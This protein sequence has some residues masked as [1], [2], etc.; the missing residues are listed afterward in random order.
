MSGALTRLYLR[1]LNGSGFFNNAI[2]MS[3]EAGLLSKHIFLLLARTAKRRLTRYQPIDWM[4]SEVHRF[5]VFL[6]N[7]G[8]NRFGLR[9]RFFNLAG[10]SILKYRELQC[11]DKLMHVAKLEGSVDQDTTL[12]FFSFMTHIFAT[13]PELPPHQP[14]NVS[15]RIAADAARDTAHLTDLASLYLLCKNGNNLEIHWD[16]AAA[17]VQLPLSM[18]VNERHRWAAHRN[19]F[20]L[21][22]RGQRPQVS[23]DVQASPPLIE[24]PLDTRKH[25]NDYIKSAVP[26]SVII[27]VSLKEGQDGT[28][29]LNEV[30]PW[31]KLFRSMKED[32]PHVVFVLLNRIDG[33]E[34]IV[35]P[36]FVR[37]LR[38]HGFTLMQSIAAAQNTDMYLGVLDSFGL[39]A[40]QVRVPGVYLPLEQDRYETEG[41]DNVQFEEI[42]PRCYMPDIM[43]SSP[44][45]KFQLDRILSAIHLPNE[46]APL[47]F[48]DFIAAKAV[49]TAKPSTRS[50]KP[51]ASQKPQ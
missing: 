46:S 15:I 43:P 34:K 30:A 17:D 33:W 27:G 31:L 40:Y 47:P 13:N 44:A 36:E 37:P 22:T 38:S 11:T 23:F 20:A 48:D 7:M 28:I 45:L 41:S 50:A 9:H 14:V 21:N 19:A 10:S 5:A 16:D 42:S 4:D 35:W 39:M 18:S 6:L 24:K 32:H 12:N 29:A 2:A 1:A 51:H 49:Q 3:M 26:G 25:Y 8:T